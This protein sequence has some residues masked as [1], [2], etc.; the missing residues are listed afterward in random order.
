MDSDECRPPP[1]RAGRG[2]QRRH[3]RAALDIRLCNTEQSVRC[4][5]GAR[6]GA[7]RDDVATARRSHHQRLKIAPTQLA[8]RT[9]LR[10]R[11]DFTDGP[12]YRP[13]D[14][15]HSITVHRRSQRAVRQEVAINRRDLF[16]EQDAVE[17]NI[18][19]SGGY[20]DAG[21][22]SASAREHRDHDKVV[23]NCVAY[24]L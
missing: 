9:A 17:G 24:I 7:D 14:L 23:A 15:V 12:A 18:P 21:R 20:G 3:Q 13:D 16:A 4:A 11:D 10:L 19:G 2:D 1:S 22:P 6:L 8:S 5:A